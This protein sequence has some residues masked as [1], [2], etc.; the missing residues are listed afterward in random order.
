[1]LYLLDTDHVSLIQRNNSEGQ[2]I[3]ARLQNI[4]PDDYGVSIVTYMEQIDGRLV[5][6]NGAKTEAAQV[7]GFRLLHENLRFYKTIA[8]W[9]FTPKAATVYSFLRSQLR[10]VG[11]QDLRIA[12]IGLANDAVV[13]T[14]NV[15]DFS[16]VPGLTVEDWTVPESSE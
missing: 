7:N 16:K 8:V 3:Q 14:R 1:M 11:T 9:D 10:Q 13:L 2:L 6:I 15:R 5:K 12:S 4:A